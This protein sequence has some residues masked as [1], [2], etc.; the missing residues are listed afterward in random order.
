MYG[1]RLLHK[2]L[3][4]RW[5]GTHCGVNALAFELLEV[6]AES[7]FPDINSINT[8]EGMNGIDGLWLQNKHLPSRSTY[9]PQT[10]QGYGLEELEYQY[11]QLVEVW[12]RNPEKNDLA[13]Q[14]AY[15]SHIVA[16][17]CT[18]PHQHGRLI[19]V[20]KRR[21]LGFWQA[22]SDWIED[23]DRH[24][25]GHAFFELNAMWR[26]SMKERVKSKLNGELIRRARNRKQRSNSIIKDHMMGVSR[27]IHKLKLHQEYMKS[28]WT[29]RVD[30]AMNKVV[31]PNIVSAVA[32]YWYLASEQR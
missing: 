19:K 23:H 29:H 4:N 2:L 18:P 3:P 12:E 15:L 16:D 14:M 17:V 32:T 21:W 25:W 30:R 24:G 20:R 28:G 6:R 1:G 5:P 8:Y 10:C 26:A 27:K 7:K 13:K 22:D 11:Q 31:L 9:N